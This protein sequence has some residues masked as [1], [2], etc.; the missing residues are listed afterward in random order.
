[1]K[2]NIC[3]SAGW[4]LAKV[5]S[6]RY[7]GDA[8]EDNRKI[9]E[10]YTLGCKGSTCLVKEPCF[11][12]STSNVK[13]TLTLLVGGQSLVTGEVVFIIT[14]QNGTPGYTYDWEV[15]VDWTRVDVITPTNITSTFTYT[16]T[17]SATPVNYVFTVDVTDS[18]GCIAQEV[19]TGSTTSPYP[20]QPECELCIYPNNDPAKDC[21]WPDNHANKQHLKEQ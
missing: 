15:T 17:P 21:I 3:G 20:P 5:N 4:V 18:R 7:G 9:L 10:A 14:P 12:L 13:C 6:I 2:L 11:P 8:C 19:F 1:M 16:G